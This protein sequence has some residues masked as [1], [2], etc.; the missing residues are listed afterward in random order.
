MKAFLPTLLFFS[1]A[2]PS[3]AVDFRRDVR[4]ILASRCYDCH[5]D[6]KPKGGL[7]LT[8]RANALKGGKSELP[9]F[10]PGQGAKSE[11]IVRLSSPDHEEQMPPKG[12]RLSAREIETLKRWID[13]GAE[14]P[15]NVK[16]WAYEPPTRAPTPP[17]DADFSDWAANPVDDFV[18]KRL[19]DAQLSPSREAEPET[20]VRRM[21]LDLTGLPPAPAEVDDFVRAWRTE[22]HQEAIGRLADRLLASPQFGVR[23]A[24]PWLDLARYADS[25]GFQRDDL[26]DLW[27]YRDWVVKALNGDMPFDRFTIEQLAGDLLPNATEEQ[28]IATGFNRGTP[29]NVEAGTEP[30][31]NRVNQVFDRVNT[32][33]AVWLGS[34]IECSQCHDHKFD[35]FT[36]RD[37]Y[38]LFA[39]FN[40]T[41]LEADR[42]NP[43]TPGSIKFIGPYHE[44]KDSEKEAARA[45]LEEERTK[46]N[47][48]MTARESNPPPSADLAEI[49]AAPREKRT[50]AQAK[51]LADH[52]A[53]IDPAYAALREQLRKVE[54]RLGE[55]KKVQSL[56]MQEL[57][58][59][60]PSALFNRGVYTDRGEAV[61]P[62]TPAILQSAEPAAAAPRTRLD[63]ARWLV[64]RD[65]PLVARVVVNR[66]WAE[67]FGRGL[68]GTPEDFG[69]KGEPPTH[70]E[71]LDWLAVD[72][73]ESGWSMKAVLRRIVT[74][75]TY[76]QSSRITPEL[77]ARDDQNK[78]LA[79]GP[80]VRLE[81]EAIRDNALAIAGLLSLKRGGPP[82]RPP[83]PDGLWDKVGGEKYDYVVSAG[84]EKFRRGLY[85]VLKRSA[86]YPSFVN[87]DA[88]ARMA[89]TVRRSRSNTPLQALT[90]LNDPVY[91]EAARAF[92]KRIVAEQPDADVAVRVRHAFRLALA[93]EPKA[94]EL[95][96]LQGL[97][98]AER[99]AAGEGAAWNAVATALLNLDE[100]I[101]KG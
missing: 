56:V 96:T 20:I 6:Q 51:K 94:G 8:S 58:Q 49:S 32:L 26:H 31:E 89:C 18:L 30:E 25:H 37:Y 64:S 15:D 14:W 74:S 57:P 70:P 45:K 83:Q 5:A 21:T 43:K 22:S 63:L 34:T 12:D 48:E 54:Q 72:F 10:I 16:H 19:A 17:V 24:R 27:L 40:S 91:V 52:Y 86:P 38:R 78:L 11:M 71:L 101:T 35:P 41:A 93:R 98:E 75:A 73:M 29:C 46:L 23:W 36:R 79:R 61:E 97:F 66:W 1:C 82:I 90:L 92:A 28:L 68:V 100:T 88:G 69:I 44:L 65:N 4:P 80:R 67:L 99:A 2:L 50:P 60:R 47:A 76:R 62:G 55:L 87:F 33:G 81:A 39:F 9:A 77:L 85:V 59:A 95:Q 53:S 84:E 3:F 7:R 42:A 13:E